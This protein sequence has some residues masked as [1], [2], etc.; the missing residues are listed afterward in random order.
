M[1][2]NEV[3]ALAERLLLDFRSLANLLAEVVQL[4]ATHVTTAGDLNLVDFGGS[5][6]GRY[7][8]RPRR[9]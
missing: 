6:P 4:G 9:S 3:F 8:R 7:A 5:E 1:N 2:A